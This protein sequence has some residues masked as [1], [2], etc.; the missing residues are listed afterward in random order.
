MKLIYYYNNTSIVKFAVKLELYELKPEY[1]KFC[2]YSRSLCHILI[3]G[4]LR[5]ARFPDLYLIRFG[6]NFYFI[7]ASN[8]YL[9]VG[10]CFLC[11][12]FSQKKF[13]V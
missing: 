9:S 5:D 1:N 2:I 4:W 13:P 8:T 10:I 12:S 7:E 6:V 11:K 3:V